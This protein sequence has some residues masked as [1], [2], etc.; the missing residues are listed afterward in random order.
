MS[1]LCSWVTLVLL[2]TFSTRFYS[3]LA[4]F[5]RNVLILLHKFL[6][7]VFIT[8]LSSEVTSNEKSDTTLLLRKV[9]E[10]IGQPRNYQLSPEVGQDK[11]SK[12]EQKRVEKTV[13][14]DASLSLWE[15]GR[16][17][18]DKQKAEGSGEWV[19]SRGHTLSTGS[20][21]ASQNKGS[22]CRS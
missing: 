20:R 11:E 13:H 1:P 6:S 2:N 15:K 21:N 3:F 16:G 22:R 17:E 5:R 14:E 9:F 4:C 12:E 10:A 19:G 8:R 7:F 18:E